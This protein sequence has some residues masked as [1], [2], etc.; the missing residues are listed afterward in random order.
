MGYAWGE[1]GAVLLV[2][3][4]R[5]DQLRD[6]DILDEAEAAL[7]YR[8]GVQSRLFRHRRNHYHGV[9]IARSSFSQSGG[10]HDVR[11]APVLAGNSHRGRTDSGRRIDSFSPGHKGTEGENQ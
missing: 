10:K 8:H 5:Y 4:R 9:E 7:A 1:I 11:V 3:L 6:G 2:R